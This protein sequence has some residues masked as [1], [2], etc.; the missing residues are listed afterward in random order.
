MIS[1]YTSGD[2][3]T[4]SL[5]YSVKSCLWFWSC[6]YME[7]AVSH[8]DTPAIDLSTLCGTSYSQWRCPCYHSQLGHWRKR[9]TFSYSGFYKMIDFDES[10][11]TRGQV[12]KGNG[13]FRV[14]RRYGCEWICHSWGNHAVLNTMLCPLITP[15]ESVDDE[16]VY[17]F[18]ATG[19]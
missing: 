3:M 17:L 12:R 9:G 6:C 1:K 14:F 13:A 11:L 7:N 16:C 2:I 19:P 10:P 15:E 8:L 5:T 18:E 4:R